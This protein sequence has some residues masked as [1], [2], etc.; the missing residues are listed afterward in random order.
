MTTSSWTWVIRGSWSPTPCPWNVHP[1]LKRAMC[2]WDHWDPVHD[3]TQLRPLYK[4]LRF[5]RTGGEF[6]SS[7]SHPGQAPLLIKLATYQAGVV[8]CFL[9]SLLILPVWGPISD[10]TQET[11]GCKPTEMTF[12]LKMN[13][14]IKCIKVIMYK[15]KFTSVYQ[16]YLIIFNVMHSR[17]TSN[18]L[19]YE[20]FCI[21]SRATP[22]CCD[23][24]DFDWVQAVL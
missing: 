10:F 7:C 12:A 20:S 2:C 22:S 17:I 15:K 19:L 9:Q 21:S 24:N 23:N 4:F 1:R 8:C 3:W 16:P 14:K 13:P 18:G 6:S 11:R 5:W